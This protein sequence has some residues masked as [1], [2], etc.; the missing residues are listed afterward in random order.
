MKLTKQPH[1]WDA[2]KAALKE[3]CVALHS[4]IKK[5][6]RPWINDSRSSSKMWKNKN[7]TN[8]NTEHGK[9]KKKI[10]IGMAISDRNKENNQELSQMI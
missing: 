1:L 6:E 8:P 7:K 3:I 4:Y 10:K 5:P 2:L 9:K